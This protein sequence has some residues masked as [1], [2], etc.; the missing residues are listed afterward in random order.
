MM[1]LEKAKVF[2]EYPCLILNTIKNNVKQ[3]IIPKK[4]YFKRIDKNLKLNTVML[5]VEYVLK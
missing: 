1:S 4:I 5:F 3:D 2:K